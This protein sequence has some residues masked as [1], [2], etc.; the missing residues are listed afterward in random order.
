MSDEPNI[1]PYGNSPKEIER[2]RR[3]AYAAAS[4]PASS[5]IDASAPA[6]REQEE[7]IPPTSFGICLEVVK[8]NRSPKTHEEQVAYL[9]NMALDGY[10]TAGERAALRCAL[11]DAASICDGLARVIAAENRGRGGKGA[12]TKRGLELEAVA[13][14]CGDAIWAMREKIDVPRE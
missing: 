4:L 3:K 12:V 8:P 9:L 2:R 10:K 6:R 1:A 7:E 11:G 13:K 14:R 5:H